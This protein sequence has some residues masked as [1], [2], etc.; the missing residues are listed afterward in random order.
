VAIEESLP[1]NPEQPRH[2]DCSGAGCRW[3]LEEQVDVTGPQV[4]AGEVSARAR[5]RVGLQ[6][7]PDRALAGQGHFYW[8][9]RLTGS[10]CDAVG[11]FHQEVS[12]RGRTSGTTLSLTLSRVDRE[13]HE[14]RRCPGTKGSQIIQPPEGQYSITV[15]ARAGATV[16][17]SIPSPLQGVHRYVLLDPSANVP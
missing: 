15:E 16:E 12:V 5:N 14:T 17:V 2:V 7:Q 11:T 1:S 3:L 6:A 10:G 4:I 8:L 9:E 13:F